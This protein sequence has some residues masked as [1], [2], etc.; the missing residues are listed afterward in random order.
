MDIRTAVAGEEVRVVELINELI[1]ELGGSPLPATDAAETT[2]LFIN[3]EFE[4]AVVIAEQNDEMVG[5]C[6]LTYQPS[7]RTLGRY[8]IIQEMY[9][10]PKFRST[11]LGAEL[12]GKAEIIARDAGCPMVE[13]STPP[14]GERAENFYRNVGLTQV[15]V[16]M[17]HQF[18]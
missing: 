15:G 9:V 14:N 18:E 5:V 2:A 13:L 12:I 11:K 7:I 16:R 6:T 10:S 1:I 4:G 8:A 3:G 17:R